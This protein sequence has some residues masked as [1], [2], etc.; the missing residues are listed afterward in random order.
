MNINTQIL[1]NTDYTDIELEKAPIFTNRKNAKIFRDNNMFFIN[2]EKLLSPFHVNRNLDIM[3]K[4]MKYLELSNTMNT[5]GTMRRYRYEMGSR[6]LFVYLYKMY[7]AVPVFYRTKSYYANTP[8][9]IVGFQF[10]EQKKLMM[11]KLKFSHIFNE[12]F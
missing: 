6:R 9:Q 12:K 5:F 8:N 11:F 2:S 10:E 7:K 1:N 4:L 3:E